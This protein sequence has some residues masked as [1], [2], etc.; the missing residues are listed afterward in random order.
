MHWWREARFGMFIHWGLFSVPAGTW[1]GKRVPGLGEWIMHDAKIPVEEYS[2]LAPQFDPVEFNA[3]QWV[4]IAKAAGAKYIV[5]TAK[6]HEGFA[7]F[8]TRVDKFNICDATPFT[9]DPIADLAAACRRHGIRFGLYYSQAQDWHHA[10]GTPDGEHWDQSQRGDPSTYLHTVAV[11]QVKEILTRYRPAIFWS[12]APVSAPS[13]A[14]ALHDLLKLVP[15]IISNNRLGGGYHGDIETREQFIPTVGNPSRDWETCMTMNDTWGYKSFDTN[16]KPA[17][18][19]LRNLIEIASKGGNYLLNV[20]PDDQ[21]VIPKPQIDRLQA[22]GNWLRLNGEAIYGTTAGPYRRL[23]FDG[24]TTLKGNTLYLHVFKWP[25]GE[26]KLAGLETPIISANALATGQRLTTHKN[27]DGSREIAK[28]DV[29]DPIATVIELK[30]SGPPIVNDTASAI[31]PSTDHSFELKAAEAKILGHILVLE[32]E[33]GAENLGYWMDPSD[34]AQWIVN[35]PEKSATDYRV[36]VEFACPPGVGGSRYAI[37]VD[38]K[39][40]GIGGIV[41]ETGAWNAYRRATLESNLKLTPGYHTVQ[42]VA[43]AMPSMAVM[44]LRG[45]T[46]L[47]MHD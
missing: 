9:R 11:P 10:G 2:Q 14:A 5:I 19:L 43:L 15:G 22:I 33:H 26:L 27:E 39:E 29:L 40:T 4:S 47:P 23:P 46:L 21:G 12:D 3:D 38:G 8:H 13:D 30:L 20:S 45:L 7:M 37:E 31:D 1:A 32:G 17:E 6:H 36:E 41:A 28:P 42:I 34:K 24:R 44:N 25:A 18:T 35:V 16:Y